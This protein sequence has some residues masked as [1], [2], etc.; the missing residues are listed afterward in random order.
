MLHQYYTTNQ[1]AFQSINVVECCE[2][3]DLLLLWQDLGDEDIPHC[4]KICEAITT[5]W[6]SWFIGLKR[7]LA[8]A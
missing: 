1:I 7:K 2:F 4:T 3:C 8:V 5:A 6:K